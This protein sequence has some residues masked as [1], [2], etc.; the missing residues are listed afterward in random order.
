MNMKLSKKI[1]MLGLG[2][3]LLG[4]CTSP[5]NIEYFEG[6]PNGTTLR[7]LEA[8]SVTLQPLDQISIIVNSRDPQIS[9]MFNM[10]YQSRRLGQSQSLSSGNA[11]SS[12]ETGVVGYTVDSNGD[13]DFPILGKIHAAGLRR[14]QLAAEI[15][16]KLE[17]SKQI[18]DPV[19]TIDYMNLGVTVLGE[20]SRPGRYKID[21]D[22][23]TILDAIGIAGDLNIN[24]RRNDVT[25]LRHVGDQDVVYRMNLNRVDSL[26]MSPGYYIQQS[27][28]VYVAPNDKRKRESTINGNN[29][30]S[31]AFWISFTSLL[32]SIAVLIVNIAKK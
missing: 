20:V 23:F 31:T 32:T 12:S 25:L 14:E 9:M 17:E 13:I 22:R 3:M 24:S 27:D 2:A 10:P 30:R 26:Y 18:K 1:A 15:K 21:R 29:V 6:V 19:V 16:Q 8:K 28:V 4:A 11:V 5:K 7:A